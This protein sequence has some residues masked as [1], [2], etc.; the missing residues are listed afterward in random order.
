MA[1][2][3]LKKEFWFPHDAVVDD[4]TGKDRTDALFGIDI[5]HYQKKDLDFSTLAQQNV[6]FVYVKASQG[7]RTTG[8]S[9]TIGLRSV[10][11]TTSP[12]AP[13]IFCQPKK[14][15]RIWTKM[16]RIPMMFASRFSC[17]IWERRREITSAASR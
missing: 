7:G 9:R 16:A 17:A 1:P 6:R 10:K 2:F 3:A 5:S 11:R 8:F 13:I 14:M 12:V 15:T 4:S